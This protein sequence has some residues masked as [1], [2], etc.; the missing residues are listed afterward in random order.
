MH[1]HRIQSFIL[2]ALLLV[3]NP[4][5]AAAGDE[6]PSPPATQPSVGDQAKDFT[7]NTLNNQPVRLAE[8]TKN[9]P[10][11][12]VVLRGW[13]GYQCPICNRQVGDLITHGHELT[14]TGARVVLVYPGAGDN[15][16][17]H[18]EDF[19]G[20]KTLPE[21]FYFVIDP[22][23][24]FVSDYG[25]RWDAAR[26]NAYPATFVIGADGKIMFEK[27]SASHGDRATAAQIL[28]AIPAPK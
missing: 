26:E 18:A 14:A 1:L 5:N 2:L 15:L 24:T 20:G 13:V 25:L 8:L 9:G 4:R 22:M 7:L 19:I 3:T 23:M 27:I 12:L 17:S 16:K 11:V 21:H 28:A 6:S 10:V